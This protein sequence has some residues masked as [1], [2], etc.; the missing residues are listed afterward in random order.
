[1][2]PWQN[3]KVRFGQRELYSLNHEKITVTGPFPI[4]F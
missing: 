2:L 4:K 3:K 1:M